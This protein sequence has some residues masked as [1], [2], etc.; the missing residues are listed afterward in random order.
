VFI[1]EGGEV[2]SALGLPHS[3]DTIHLATVPIVMGDRPL[4]LIMLA[5]ARRPFD[6]GEIAL[7]KIAES[8]VD[9]AVVQTYAYHE[10]QQRNKELQTIFQVDQIRDRNLPFDEMLNAVL[11]ELST[12]IQAEMGFIM[13]FDPVGQQLELRAVTHDDLFRVS[14]YYK[15]IDEMANASL[16]KGELV[17]DNNL[18]E[19]IRSIM[20][21]PLILNNEIIGVLG[22]VNRYGPQGFTTEDR[23]LLR[24]I[25]SQMDTAIFEGLERR[26][27]RRVLGRSVDPH[28]LER[29]LKHREV[30]FL[31]G[32]RAELSV[33]YADLRGSTR[34]AERTDAELLVEFINDFLGRMT[35]IILQ[36]E[37][38]LDKYVGDEVMALFG[39]PFPQPDHALRAVRVGLEMQAAYEGLMETWGERGV[40]VPPLGVG[41]STGEVI[42]GEMGCPKRTDYTVIGRAANLGSRICDVAKDGQVLISEQTYELVKG[43]VEA[44][45][46]TGLRLKG[47]EHEITAYHVIGLAG[48][49]TGS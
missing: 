45:P 29:L 12:V 43:E 27:L 21:I 37:A 31:K 24:A 13:L 26:R 48:P 25:G 28:V 8:Q 36:N 20:C 9:S 42:V 19:T 3:T 1:W 44:V 49:G 34:L 16:Q 38:T 30:D 4:G 46:L 40:D 10:L 18:G 23:R 6:A 11:Q 7:L 5:R 17:F 39:A 22:M 33:L 15:L 2:T 32:E 14:P 47:M 35:D 41:I